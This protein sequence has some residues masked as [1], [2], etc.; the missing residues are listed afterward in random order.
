MAAGLTAEGQISLSVYEAGRVV[1]LLLALTGHA[2]RVNFLL[3]AQQPQGHWGASPC[4]MRAT[5]VL[6]TV[7]Q[8]EAARSCGSAPRCAELSWKSLEPATPH[9]RSR[10]RQPVRGVRRPGA[11]RPLQITNDQVLPGIW[12]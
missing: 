9:R 4:G 1:S 8:H 10:R 5:D 6:L 3:T 12:A 7:Q 2:E 11:C